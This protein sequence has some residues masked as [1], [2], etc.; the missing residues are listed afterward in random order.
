MLETRIIGCISAFLLTAPPPNLEIPAL[1]EQ[2]ITATV[3]KI[4]ELQT[5]HPN[6]SIVLIGMGPMALLACHVR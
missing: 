1:L 3:K 2:M 4:A 6:R 5:D